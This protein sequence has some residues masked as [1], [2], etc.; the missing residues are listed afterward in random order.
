M[1]IGILTYIRE[2]ANLGTNMQAYSTL[3]ALQ[4]VYPDARVELIDYAWRRGSRR[5][6]LTQLSLRSLRNDFAR[7]AKYDDFFGGML[8]M[9][10]ERLVCADPERAAEFI[11]RQGYRAIYVGADTLLELKGAPRGRL[12]AYWLDPRID[13]AKFLIAASSHNLVYSSL[14]SQRIERM[15]AA[16]ERF[17]LLGVRDEPTLRLLSQLVPEGDPRLQMVPDPTFTYDIDY[18]HV[19]RYLKRSRVAFGAKVVC[20]HLLR[21]TRW[22]RELADG[23]RRCGFKVASLRPARWADYQFTDLSPFEQ[24]GLYRYF[25][26]VITHRFHDAIFCFKNRTPV[27]FFPEYATDVTPFHESKT[28]TLFKSFGLDGPCYIENRDAVCARFLLDRWRDA[29]EAFRARDGGMEKMLGELRERYLGFA[30]RSR[31]LVPGAEGTSA[32]SVAPEAT[33]PRTGAGGDPVKVVITAPSLDTGDNVSGISAVT[34]FII[35]ANRS[36]RYLH[37]ELGRKD[38]QR[39]DLGWLIA[40]LRSYRDWLLLMR[41]GR[42]LTIHFNLALSLASILRDVPLVLLA[43]LF[44][45]RMIVHLHGG[46]YLLARTM[47]WWLR[48]PLRWALSGRAPK[49]VLSP[50]E[51]TALRKQLGLEPIHVLANCVEI[52]PA[53][54]LRR[55]PPPDRPLTLL[56]LGRISRQKGLDCVLAALRALRESGVRFR[57]V[58][59]GRGAD[60]GRYVPGF[61]ELLGDDFRF[62]GVVAGRDKNELLES[63]DLFVL[64]SL[65]EG[66]PMAL[67]EAMSFGVVPVTTRVGSLGSVIEEGVNGLFVDGTR[68]EELAAAIARLSSDRELLARLGA[69]ARRYVIDNC[70]P[71]GYIARLNRI[72]DRV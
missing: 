56:F 36:R 2:Y 13:C 17:S 70:D 34:R 53:D 12:T 44:R 26:L 35:G 30:R 37:F 48:L 8:T 39:R 11:G 20:L 58:M 50:A 16:L 31:L 6:Y 63:S 38:A 65:F 60:E 41:D 61:R 19:E 62:A 7:M 46:E 68:P 51:E 18:G 47:P 42:D 29:V 3:R 72:Y 4:G 43:R 28:L 15:R 5:P 59:A 24:V 33:H 57:F 10:G 49:V 1:K 54:G 67:L 9:S 40:L 27:I 32:Y 66:L 23:F 25:D 22:G 55:P 71:A 64:P 21:D 52:P 69:N 45:R 14:D